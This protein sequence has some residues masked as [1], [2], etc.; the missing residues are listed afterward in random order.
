MPTNFSGCLKPLVRLK[1][2]QPC[3]LKRHFDFCMRQVVSY[4]DH[5]AALDPDRIVWV[6][7]ST[8]QKQCLN[9]RAKDKNGDPTVYGIRMVE[10]CLEAL[11]AK[12]I[13]SRHHAVELQERRNF[14]ID[15]A[16][17]VTPHDALCVKSG[18]CCRFVGM[19]KVSETRWASGHGDVWFVS[20][21]G[22]KD[23]VEPVLVFEVGKGIVYNRNEEMVKKIKEVIEKEKS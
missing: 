4:L 2:D 21:R 19:G 11:R 23:A 18:T 8:I 3:S 12:G 5:Q 10:K 6:R 15:H 20:Q 13:I 1:A 17:V 22:G 16:F 9:Y 7:A 14:V